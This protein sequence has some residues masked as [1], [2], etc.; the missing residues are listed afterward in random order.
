MR[1][2][3]LRLAVPLLLGCVAES[4]SAQRVVGEV[5]RPDSVTPAAQVLVEWR[6]TRGA[7]QRL[8]TDQQGRFRLTLP[9]ADSVYMRVLRPGFQPQTHRPFF[10]AQGRTVST[11]IVIEDRPIVL[12]SVRV[13][14]ESACTG[15]SD[16][17]AWTLLEQARTA[18]LAASLAER[19]TSLLIDAVEYEGG[20]TL[21]GAITLR[22]SSIRRSGRSV[23]GTRAQRDSIFRFGFVRR[24]SDTSYYHA[25]TPDVLLDERFGRQYCLTLM[26]ADSSPPGQL[27]VRFQPARRPGPGIADV[28]GV[29]WLDDDRYLLSRI[30]FEYLNVPPHH[31]V[32]GLG[33]Y[34]EYSALPTGHWLLREW[35][36]RMPNLT[37]SRASSGLWAKRRIVHRVSVAGRTIYSDSTGAA[38]LERVQPQTRR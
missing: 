14:G 27:G 22:D 3:I 30:E 12:S 10:V 1:V 23:P 35:T 5:Q 18:I 19:D 4:L 17:Q 36:F 31:R 2:A 38:I 25:P 15:R 7:V 6:T 9:T 21:A 16:A 29:I 33:G 26:M 24:T 37:R 20:V 34:L 8:L 13:A 11:R 28:T 32:D